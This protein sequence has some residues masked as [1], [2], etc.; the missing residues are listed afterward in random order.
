[1]D[2]E[3]IGPAPAFFAKW[4][5]QYRYHILLRGHGARELFAAFP[6]PSDWRIDVDP[7]NML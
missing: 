4:R 7:V 3:L 6:L 1:M 5:G 2:I